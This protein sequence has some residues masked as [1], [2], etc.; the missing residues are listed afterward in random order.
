[1][2]ELALVE[3]ILMACRQAATSHRMSRV[4]A[5]HITVGEMAACPD[6]LRFAW[7]ACRGRFPPLQEA[8]LEIR[9]V[10]ATWGCSRC[11]T[12]YEEPIG[13]CAACGGACPRLQSGLELQVDYLEGDD[14]RQEPASAPQQQEPASAPQPTGE[15][16]GR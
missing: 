13:R 15:C 16:S 11:G 14:S 7:E 3:E 10:P 5:V 2:H 6:A 4:A 1:M 8:A 9:T 12:A